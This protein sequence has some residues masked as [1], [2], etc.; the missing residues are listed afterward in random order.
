[1]SVFGG[2]PTGQFTKNRDVIPDEVLQF[3]EFCI[4]DGAG[5]EPV[6]HRGDFSV[7]HKCIFILYAEPG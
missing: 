5:H 2:E 7:R 3:N 4:C 1:M 6:G